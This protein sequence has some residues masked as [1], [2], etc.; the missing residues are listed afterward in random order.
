MNIL[1]IGDD[2][3]QNFIYVEYSDTPRK[4][5]STYYIH[6]EDEKRYS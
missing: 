3:K 1:L 5:D 2:Q 4:S 6:T